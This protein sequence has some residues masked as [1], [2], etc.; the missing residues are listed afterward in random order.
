MVL[1]FISQFFTSSQTLAYRLLLAATACL[2]PAEL[3][4]RLQEPGNRRRPLA[5]P[6][7]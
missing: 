5:P 4:D 6:G 1:L 2:E 7:R 3:R